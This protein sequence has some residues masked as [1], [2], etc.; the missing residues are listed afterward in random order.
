MAQPSYTLTITCGRPPNRAVDDFHIQPE[1]IAHAIATFTGGNA[2]LTLTARTARLHVEALA[3]LPNPRYW[4]QRMGEVL[5]CC[6]LEVPRIRGDYQLPSP[7][8]F[9]IR[10]MTP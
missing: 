8:R 5:N 3:Q 10:E 9:D 7:V 1:R 4:Q 2:E 6:W